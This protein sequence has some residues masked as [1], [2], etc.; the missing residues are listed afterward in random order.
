L[1]FTGTF[2]PFVGHS[3]LAFVESIGLLDASGT[4]TVVVV[5]AD[6]LG[7]IV[8]DATMSVTHAKVNRFI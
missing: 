1:Y 8:S 5:S 6:A 4:Q 7:S 2:V 3:P